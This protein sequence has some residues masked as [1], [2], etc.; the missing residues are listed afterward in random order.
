MTLLQHTR[1]KNH[2][3][4]PLYQN[5]FYS[6]VSSPNSP[7]H[8]HG[9][10]NLPSDQ[11]YTQAGEALP[12]QYLQMRIAFLFL[13]GAGGGGCGR[14]AAGR[15]R[16]AVRQWAPADLGVQ[17]GQ[18]AHWMGQ[19]WRWAVY[20]G[21]IMGGV[22]MRSVWVLVMVL[23]LVVVQSHLLHLGREKNTSFTISTQSSHYYGFAKSCQLAKTI[24][25]FQ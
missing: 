20:H 7:K 21:V 8:K 15:W 22:I 4:G 12:H 1:K 5:R 3:L 14:F 16:G 2:S 10:L 18:N 6:F 11:R 24:I 23:Q 25:Q 17:L 13:I 9:K 19:Y